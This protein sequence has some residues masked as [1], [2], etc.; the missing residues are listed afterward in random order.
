MRATLYSKLLGE[1]NQPLGKR[2]RLYI[3]LHNT[4]R[5]WYNPQVIQ[6]ARMNK[7]RSCTNNIVL[8]EFEG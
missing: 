6:K 2:W 4:L 3:L 7:L 8:A 5:T 1:Y